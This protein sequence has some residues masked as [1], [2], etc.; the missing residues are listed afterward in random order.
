MYVD[1]TKKTEKGKRETI[2]LRTIYNEK[3]ALLYVV[4]AYTISCSK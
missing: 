2:R 3:L 1:V 4:E